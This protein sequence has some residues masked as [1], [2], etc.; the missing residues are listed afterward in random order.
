VATLAGIAAA[1]SWPFAAGGLGLYPI[2]CFLYYVRD[3]YNA[4]Q[5]LTFIYYAKINL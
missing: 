1:L 3:E 5:R 2:L 4:S